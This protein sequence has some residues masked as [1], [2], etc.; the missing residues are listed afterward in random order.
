MKKLVAAFAAV[1]ATA[2]IAVGTAGADGSGP[3]F[4]D[5]GFAC[6][7]IDRGGGSLLTFDSAITWYQSGKVH[8]RCE[9]DGTP[10]ATVETTTGFSCGLGPFGSTT[11]SKNVVRRE[12]RVQLDCFGH[13]NPNSIDSASAAGYGAG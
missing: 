1:V 2:A 9:A 3:L 8:L 7:V 10:G 5:E 6:G 4:T 13:V 12:G 11:Q